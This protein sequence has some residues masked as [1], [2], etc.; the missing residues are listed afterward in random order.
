MSKLANVYFSLGLARRWGSKVKCYSLHPG[1]INT[2][3]QK[4]LDVNA[5]LMFISMCLSCQ[6]TMKSVPQGA[7][8]QIYAAVSDHVLQYKSGQYLDDC[9]Q[10]QLEIDI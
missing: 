8:T 3:L 1:G 7:S 5:W 6:L 10:G 9:K 4:H 2:E